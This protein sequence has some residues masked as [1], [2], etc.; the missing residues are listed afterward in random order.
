MTWGR[1]NRDR[2]VVHEK[3]LGARLKK[4]KDRVVLLS[5]S[6]S[7]F[8]NCIRHEHLLEASDLQDF[9]ITL[10]TAPDNISMVPVEK[11][12]SGFR[13]VISIGLFPWRFRR[14]G[15]DILDVLYRCYLI[16]RIKPNIVHC[17][18]HRPATLF[19]ALLAKF[20]GAKLVMEWV[21]LFSRDGIGKIRQGLIPRFAALCD[22][23]LEI[24]SK[25]AADHLIVISTYL[26]HRAIFDLGIG[27]AKVSLVR[28]GCMPIAIDQTERSLSRSDKIIGFLGFEL[29]DLDDLLDALHAVVK[30]NT[31]SLSASLVITG[32]DIDKLDGR[33]PTGYD[34]YLIRKGWLS[35]EAYESLLTE[36]DAFI[37]PLR[38]DPRNCA[39]WPMKVGDYLSTGSAVVAS[40]IGEIKAINDQYGCLYAYEHPSEISVILNDIFINGTHNADRVEKC[41][42]LAQGPL[43]WST[44]A[45]VMLE[46]YSSAR[47]AR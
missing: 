46:A 26:K 45:G 12:S 39:K 35:T 47:A 13:K 17:D 2:K 5:Q 23:W 37:L 42:E 32:K 8:Q 4:K 14:G 43:S 1:R 18:G 33:I 11:L 9:D 27:D 15:L 7:G 24:K 31:D 21:D 19:P 28:G 41:I 3:L 22:E 25:R 16:F 36:L 20:M 30:L 6:V 40:N 10:V 44:C 29:A 34:A 38:N